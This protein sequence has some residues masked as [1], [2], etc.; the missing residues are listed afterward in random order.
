M[1]MYEARSVE[2]SWIAGM[3]MFCYIYLEVFIASVHEEIM[4]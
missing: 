1:L 3:V 2:L 4:A